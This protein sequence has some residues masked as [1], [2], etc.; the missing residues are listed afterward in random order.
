MTLP[1][2]ERGEATGPTSTGQDEATG[3]TSTGQSGGPG[4]TSAGHVL[5]LEVVQLQINALE[6]SLITSTA[7]F[8]NCALHQFSYR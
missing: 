2:R 6:N 4:P 3:P 5:H 7:P 1:L 8:I